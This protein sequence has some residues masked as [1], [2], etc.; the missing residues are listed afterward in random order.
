[1]VELNRAEVK[2]KHTISKKFKSKPTVEKYKYK[3]IQDCINITFNVL[4]L[5][6]LLKMSFKN[7]MLRGR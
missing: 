5:M 2:H 6:S 3:F 7:A 4:P 1:M